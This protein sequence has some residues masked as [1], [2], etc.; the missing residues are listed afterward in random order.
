[1][2][3]L[4]DTHAFLWFISGSPALSDYARRLIENF[5]N[6]RLLSIASLWEMSIKASIGKLRISL[7]F[8][9]FFTEHIVGNAIEILHISPEHLDN[10]RGLPFHHKDPFDRIVNS[11]GRFQ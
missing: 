11:L 2:K 1:M 7:P 4:L 10:L 5:S 6:E 3:I 9:E 8:T